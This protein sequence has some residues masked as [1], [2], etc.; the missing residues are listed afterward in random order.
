MQGRLIVAESF[1]AMWRRGIVAA[2]LRNFPAR[3]LRRHNHATVFKA[4]KR[5]E[6]SV[7]TSR[8]GTEE[9]KRLLAFNVAQVVLYDVI[10]DV[11]TPSAL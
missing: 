3:E 8:V 7:I 5:S 1:A 10:L 9:V 4:D 11:I 6:F 2:P